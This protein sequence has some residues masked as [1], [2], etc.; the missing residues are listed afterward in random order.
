MKR[1]V[2][3]LVGGVAVFFVAATWLAKSPETIAADKANPAARNEPQ[4]GRKAALKAFMRKKLA[5][6]Q[7]VLEGLAVED[8]DL[9]L[10]GT[11]QLKATGAAAEFMAH[12]DA[13]YAEYAGDFRRVVERMERLAKE[14]KLDGAALAYVDLTLNCV[15]CHKYVRNVLVALP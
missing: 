8:F 2:A 4:A 15:E 6:S 9:I 12:N 10:Q 11:K 1:R 14:S 3:F 13:L 5:A 7:N